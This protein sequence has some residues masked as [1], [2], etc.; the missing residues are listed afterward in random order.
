MGSIGEVTWRARRRWTTT[1]GRVLVC[2]PVLCALVGALA[3]TG[4]GARAASRSSPTAA[5]ATLTGHVTAPSANGLT[6][7][8]VAGTVV[9]VI[10]PS[11]PWHAVTSD[12]NGFYELDDLP[13]ATYTVSFRLSSSQAESS[14]S[15]D[16]AAGADT[17]LD[18]P[19]SAP[20]AT[21][22]G[23]ITDRHRRPL[24][25]MAVALGPT[26]AAACPATAW[27]G[28]TAT[29][30][31]DGVYT[32]SLA[33]GTYELRVLDGSL[34]ADAGPVSATAG[35][36]TSAGF[37]LT[38]VAVP[39]GS[40]PGHA[41][42]DLAWL[43]AERT[44]LGLPAGIVLDPRWAQEC[45]AHDGYERLN[46]IL[47][48]SENPQAP[49][50]SIGGAWAGL[51]SVLAQSRW[52]PSHDPWQD[53]PIHLMQLL[54]PSLSVIGLDDSA[55]RQC[56]T[57]YPGL[58]RAPVERETVTTYP[59][60]GARGV[61]A[62]ERAREA[63]FV[64][65]QFVGVPAGRTAGRE[66]F[67]YLNEPGRTGQSPVHVVSATLAQGRQ[68]LAIRWVDTTTRTVGR[69][70]TG[71]I[72]IPVKPLRGATTYRATVLIQDRSGTV[73]HGWAFTTAGS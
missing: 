37:H 52:T 41:P 69:Y 71:A 13:A 27:C 16:L 7:V 14:T 46:G 34:V 38:P 39:A 25:G 32:V 49:G 18:D 23:L 4:T 35:Q 67:V 6:R 43:N 51:V 30:G 15:L 66:L 9:S 63:P 24:P 29:T 60:D 1:T 72:V 36:T 48:Q 10:P 58:L 61:P 20:V 28:T 55:G 65:G 22:T 62:R 42:R 68:K 45:A 26:D 59:Q 31:P 19:L 64:P 57:T 44:R 47:S 17:T 21:V 54:T 12:A 3:G 40:T 11:G 56:A 33:P 53:A 5:S 8:P 2:A 70:L 73:S 50:A